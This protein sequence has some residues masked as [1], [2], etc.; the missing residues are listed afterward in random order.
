MV[1]PTQQP[2]A[3]RTQELMPLLLLAGCKRLCLDLYLTV[4]IAEVFAEVCAQL[5]LSL[6]NPVDCSPLGSSVHGILQ[7]RIL[8]WVAISYSRSFS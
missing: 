4:L 5:C 1:L 7:A 3:H 8:E 6:C 2:Q